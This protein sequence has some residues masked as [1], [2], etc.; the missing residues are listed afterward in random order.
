[1]TNTTIGNT[2]EFSSAEKSKLADLVRLSMG[3]A[4]IVQFAPICGLSVS[5]LSKTLNMAL[6]TRPSQKTLAKLA[7]ASQTKGT[8][9]KDFYDAC[10]YDTA[11]IKEIT[12]NE[13]RNAKLTFAQAERAYFA[14]PAV[15]AVS[16]FLSVWVKNSNS[17][18]VDFNLY[19]N[20]NVFVISDR[21]SQFR[22]ICVSCFCQ[23]KSG[24]SVM[25]SEIMARVFAALGVADRTGIP[26][27]A[28]FYLLTDS[29]ELYDFCSNDLP[30]LSSQ[31]M[32]VLL[33]DEQHTCFCEQKL[34]LSEGQDETQLPVLATKPA[35]EI[36]DVGS[37]DTN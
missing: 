13:E 27:S 28:F 31:N 5:F 4:S 1:M 35:A 12:K 36:T 17:S 30:K 25:R 20:G 11:T 3:T 14:S 10:G 21:T 22:A 34:R 29:E 23:D 37:G 6:A 32:V 19:E 33:S 8:T 24:M 18:D 2:S 15:M 9:L 7:E 16:Q 26:E